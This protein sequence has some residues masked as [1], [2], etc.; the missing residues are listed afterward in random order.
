MTRRQHN[1]PIAAIV[2]C[3]LAYLT[4]ETGLAA[5]P[6]RVLLLHPSSRVNLR[7]ATKIRA[8]IERQWPEP[9]EFYDASLVTGRPV[10][11]IVADRYGDYLRSIFLDQN[12]DLAVV[13]GGADESSGCLD[14]PFGGFKATSKSFDHTL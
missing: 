1:R 6:K 4:C 11:E 2:L 9:L 7:A 12:L 5:A 3:L 10:D 8:E 13:V 14:S